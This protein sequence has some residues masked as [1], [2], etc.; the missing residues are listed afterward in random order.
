ML[1]RNILLF[2]IY[3]FFWRFKPL[4]TLMIVYFS[5]IMQSYTLATA[6]FAIFNISYA[7]LKIPSGLISD[8][9]GRKQVIIVA[10][11]CLFSAFCLLAI[12]GQFKVKWLLYIF[13]VIW[14]I[15]EALSA[16]TI[17][18][19]MYE[20]TQN[21]KQSDKFYVVY[22]KSMF[23]DQFGCAL[24][25]FSAMAITYF[26]PLQVVAWFAALPAFM[27]FFIS[28]YFINPNVQ[29][30]HIS[31][32]V[33]DVLIA[34]KQ[35]KNNKCLLFYALADI[36]FST[37]GDISHRLESAYFKLFASDWIINFA[38]MLKHFF[39]MLGFAFMSYLGKFSKVKIFFVSITC[40][41]VVRITALIF[42]NIG[43]PFIHMFINFFY[44]T[45]ATAKTDILQQEYKAEYRATT[46]SIIEFVKGV[47]M[48][49]IML[50]LGIFAD[51][52]S[53]YSV[54]ILLVILR[55]FGL[56]LVLMLKKYAKIS[57]QIA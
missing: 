3:Y 33:E 35:F 4:A 49:G 43:A 6:V 18:A 27:Q 28:F 23:F 9:I 44:A 40:N 46:Q 37:L 17:E 39:G 20:T 15:G 22:A 42:N 2:K 34:L 47:Y 21:L 10:N 26:L 54:M 36:Y 52:Y 48:A 11:G 32:S 29:K 38:R 8:K 41:I 7:V 14:G 31:I 13:S 19:L 57:Q 12:S 5:Q 56:F 51:A 55:I 25:A 1:Q 16:G 53:I 45:A 30:K 24:G 50:V